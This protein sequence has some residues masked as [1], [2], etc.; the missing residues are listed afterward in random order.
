MLLER[1]GLE[2]FLSPQLRMIIRTLERRPLRTL[3]TAFGIAC[4]V[5]IIVS[6][7]F[8]R[9]AIDY[10]ITVQFSQAEREDAQIAFTNPVSKR[11][12][13]A[14]VH[15][16]GVLFAEGS[17]SVPVRLRAGH[18]TYLTAISGLPE[19]AENYA[20]RWM[21]TSTPSLSRPTACCSLT[22][23]RR[24]SASTREIICRWKCWKAS[25]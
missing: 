2:K 14:I 4:S 6:G 12:Q 8:W 5:A 18:L 23:S 9:D 1:L 10:L 22:G 19:N 11:G 25:A 7:T 17:R 3:L 21:P 20:D 24:N 13:Y 15:F 16:P